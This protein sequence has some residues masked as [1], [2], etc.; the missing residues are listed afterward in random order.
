LL[1]AGV[2]ICYYSA[3]MK[4]QTLDT[5][6]YV[7]VPFCHTKCRYCD[8][9]SCA[10][11]IGLAGSYLEA[12]RAEIGA[13]A[14]THE[15]AVAKTLYIG[16]GTPSL[17]PVDAVASIVAWCR[18]AFGLA[19]EAEV[20]LEANPGTVDYEYLRAV[21]ALGINR[22][23][24]GVQSLDDGALGFL[25]RIHNA[26]QAVDAYRSARKAGLANI[27]LDLIYGLPGQNQLDWRAQLMEV[28]ALAPDHLSLYALSAESNTP[29]GEDVSEGRVVLPSADEVAELND[30]A[31]EVLGPAGYEHY[32]V[33]NLARRNNGVGQTMVCQ[34][35]LIYWRHQ[36]YLGFGA[37][38]HSFYGGVRFSNEREFECYIDMVDRAGSAVVE[39]EPIDHRRAAADRLML[40]LRLAEG[41]DISDIIV[42]LGT[43]R[44]ADFTREVS[45]LKDGGFAESDGERLR[46][47]RRGRML[48][49]E[50][51]L[52]LW[53]VLQAA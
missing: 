2:V 17:L 13:S 4:G 26:A 51:V 24:L 42:E 8:F 49:N 34:H 20:T 12:L 29:L 6:I 50:V 1:G 11:T 7:H 23:S 44:L 30:I 19:S 32:E 21:W 40:G 48:L 43:T 28:A 41:V 22:L 37:G 5:G 36:R 46:L 25:G 3:E 9:N 47:T 18:E 35:N 14:R 33:S 31:E 27:N 52:R 53:S 39:R 16:G 15:G 10:G 38:A 45:A